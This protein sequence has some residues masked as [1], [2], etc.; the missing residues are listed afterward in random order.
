M[1]EI[2]PYQ[3]IIRMRN[4]TAHNNGLNNSSQALILLS[5]SLRLLEMILI[6]FENQH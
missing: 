5:N 3:E 1:S 4:L 2:V 6:R